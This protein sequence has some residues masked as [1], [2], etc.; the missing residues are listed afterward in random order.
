MIKLGEKLKEARGMK[1]KM[2]EKV[3]SAITKM[4]GSKKQVINRKIFKTVRIVVA[5]MNPIDER[6]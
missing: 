5:Y 1:K 6:S 4:V 3:K 2:E